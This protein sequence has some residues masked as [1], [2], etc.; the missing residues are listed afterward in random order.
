M[1]KNWFLDVHNAEPSSHAG[2]PVFTQV[3][4]KPS[5]LS[6]VTRQA[7]LVVGLAVEELPQ[8]ALTASHDE[9]FVTEVEAVHEE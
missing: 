7:V 8:D 1:T 2:Q 9:F 3:P 5:D 4:T 6:G